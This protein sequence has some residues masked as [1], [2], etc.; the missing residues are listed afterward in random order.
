MDVVDAWP[1]VVSIPGLLPVVQQLHPRASGLDQ[2]DVRVHLLD[3]LEDVAEVRVTHV[4]LNLGFVLD[5]GGRQTEAVDGPAQ[6][7]VPA[8]PPQ[9]EAL[10]DRRLVDLDDLD[11]GLLEVFDLVANR[12]SKLLARIGQRLIV[13]D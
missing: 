1:D 7:L 2:V 3:V 6:V 10:P 5:D 11:S 13:A 8:V 4:R 9:W 12:E